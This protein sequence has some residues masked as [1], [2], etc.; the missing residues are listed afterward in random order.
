[1]HIRRTSGFSLLEVVF[2]VAIIAAAIIPLTDLMTTTS[3]GSAVTRDHLIA[4][5]LA[6]LAFEQVYEAATADSQASF[7]QAVATFNT[8]A[9]SVGPGGCPGVPVSDLAKKPGD[10]IMPGDGD[11]KLDPATGDP[12]YKLL[13]QRYSYT[14]TTQASA[15][16]NDTTTD[17]KSTLARVDVKV[18]WKDLQGNCQS[19]ALSSYV[20]R[21]RY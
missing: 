19:V 18:Y 8:P 1:M 15:S 5:N 9:G 13:Y 2:A 4:S 11:P 14:M 20:P 17:A 7:D 3:H 21:R 12:E 10:T 16:A 6:E